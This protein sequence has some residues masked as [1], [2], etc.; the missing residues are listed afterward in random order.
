M[1][2]YRRLQ[3]QDIIMMKSGCKMNAYLIQLQQNSTHHTHRSNHIST[4]VWSSK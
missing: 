2:A 3:I 4:S 1:G